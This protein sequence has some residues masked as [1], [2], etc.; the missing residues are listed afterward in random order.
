VIS[1]HK[2]ALCLYFKHAAFEVHPKAFLWA[3]F[4]P[5]KSFPHEAARQQVIALSFRTQPVSWTNAE[6]CDSACRATR[7][8]MDLWIT[9]YR[10]PLVVS[11]KTAPVSVQA[12]QTTQEEFGT[13]REKEWGSI[14]CCIIWM[15]RASRQ[16]LTRQ[17]F[18]SCLC[19]TQWVSCFDS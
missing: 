12:N 19:F 16:H 4:M 7:L 10:L 9:L 6:L 2:G 3:A 5:P 8:L 14:W 15:K 11:V 1:Y 18:W 17:R 13:K